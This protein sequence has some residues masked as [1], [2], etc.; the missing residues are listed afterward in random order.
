[1]GKRLT[2]HGSFRNSYSVQ[3]FRGVVIRNVGPPNRVTV[4]QSTLGALSGEDLE[5]VRNRV[6]ALFSVRRHCEPGCHFTRTPSRIRSTLD[7]FLRR[8]GT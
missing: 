1:V 3:G 6:A 4:L 8:A 2:R 5:P 7:R